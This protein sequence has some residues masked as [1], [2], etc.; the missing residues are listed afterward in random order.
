MDKYLT[1]KTRVDLSQVQKNIAPL[2]DE[3]KIIISTF[4]LNKALQ[5]LTH[6]ELK[7]FFY[8]IEHADNTTTTFSLSPTKIQKEIGLSIRSYK[9]AKIGLYQ[10][11]YLIKM[12]GDYFYFSP[13]ITRKK[14]II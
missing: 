11:G 6:S 13:D 12:P 5:D 7:L 10:K 4:V 2:N 3:Q 1:E 9:N 8:L 14:E